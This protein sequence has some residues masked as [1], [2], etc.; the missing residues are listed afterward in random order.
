[1]IFKRN[2]FSIIKIITFLIIFVIFKGWV[3][4]ETSL[5][6][7]IS[8]SELTLEDSFELEI[9]INSDFDFKWWEIEIIWLDSFYKISQKNYSQITNIN[10]K[11]KQIQTINLWFYPNKVW[12]FIIWPA[13][14]KDWESII[15]S[16]TVSVKINNKPLSKSIIDED[17]KKEKIQS[18]SNNNDENT[19]NEKNIFNEE[20]KDIRNLKYS[21]FDFNFIFLV[22][23][24][25]WLYLYIKFWIKN[26]LKQN[27][28]LNN[29]N[30]IINIETIIFDLK[31]LK[32]QRNKLI[33]NEFYKKLNLIFRKYFHFIWIVDSYSKTYKEL[34]SKINNK[35]ILSLFKQ[36]YYTEFDSSDDNSENREKIIEIFIKQID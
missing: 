12:D 6:L 8:E 10:W 20:L 34:S 29:Q 22:V 28:L 11:T 35:E 18:N 14:I 7:T 36:S 23:I 15:E 24:L 33:K 16:N 4:A 17:E 5:E 21:I 9:K 31:K 19:D 26:N 13:N 3:F 32:R 27:D 25:V 1:M 30:K 2:S